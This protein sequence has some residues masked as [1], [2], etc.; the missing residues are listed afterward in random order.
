[1]QH[2]IILLGLLTTP[3]GAEPLTLNQLS[4]RVADVLK[5]AGETAPPA[6]IAAPADKTQ[7]AIENVLNSMET[8]FGLAD[9]GTPPYIYETFQDDS[10]KGKYD[11]IR[12]RLILNAKLKTEIESLVIG[13]YGQMELLLAHELMHFWVDQ[14]SKAL[15]LGQFPPPPDK[16]THETALLSEGIAEFVK[17]EL[18]GQ[19]QGY[20]NIWKDSLWP[21]TIGRTGGRHFYHWAY[22][23]TTPILKKNLTGGIDHI[24][25]NPI[26]AK[27]VQDLF[28]Y[29]DAAIAALP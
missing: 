7:A 4:G 10:L 25:R 28:T 26:K 14:R 12:Q 3:V 22:V 1:M 18:A 19:R 20:L 13:R 11:P 9:V 27:T 23:L 29:R 17:Y 2:V 6:I 16:V 24:L 15:G 5:L 8:R 21:A